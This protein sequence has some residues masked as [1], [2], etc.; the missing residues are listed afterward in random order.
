MDKSIKVVFVVLSV[1]FKLC[2]GS[3]RGTMPYK[4]LSDEGRGHIVGM[5]ESGMKS[6]DIA[7]V[8]NVPQSNVSTILTD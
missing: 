4:I 1:I 8:L 7:Y 2:I 5:R 3:L 6:L